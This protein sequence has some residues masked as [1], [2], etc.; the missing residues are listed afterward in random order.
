VY[1]TISGLRASDSPD[2]IFTTLDQLKRV[3]AEFSEAQAFH[4]Y[5]SNEGLGTPH[6]MDS[7][8]CEDS[9]PQALTTRRN[10]TRPEEDCITTL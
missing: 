1:L 3:S 9:E 8:D 4:I 5:E 7:L 2:H 6:N 10:F